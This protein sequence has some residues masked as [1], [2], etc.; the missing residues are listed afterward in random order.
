M[1]FFILVVPEATC[2]LFL[3]SETRY[4]IS[5]P[6]EIFGEASEFSEASENSEAS[7]SFRKKVRS[8]FSI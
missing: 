1:F 7:E 5:E 6:S 3:H 2:F 4:E 8:V